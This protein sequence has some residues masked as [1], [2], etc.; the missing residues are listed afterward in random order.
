MIE[1][2]EA[3]GVLYDHDHYVGLLDEIDNRG[4]RLSDWEID[5]IDSMMKKDTAG[6]VFTHGQQTTIKQI[7]TDRVK[8]KEAP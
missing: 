2:P 3:G 4:V 8:H 7:H 5:F 1:G 6:L